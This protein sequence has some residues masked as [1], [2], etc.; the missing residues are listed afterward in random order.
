[1]SKKKGGL[2]TLLTGVAMGAAAVFLSDKKNREKTKQAADDALEKAKT[3]KK[4]LKKDPEKFVKK[5]I[6]SL[7]D[8][9]CCSCN[10]A[11]KKTSSKQ[12]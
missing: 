2:L 10:S 12:S 1:M 11:A 4:D 6:T 5:T 8:K 9:L 3:V 7:K